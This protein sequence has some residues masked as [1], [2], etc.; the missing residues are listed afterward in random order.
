MDTLSAAIARIR[1]SSV[2]Q[3]TGATAFY[4]VNDDEVDRL[5]DADG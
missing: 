3:T 2:C 4:D 5:D 1:C